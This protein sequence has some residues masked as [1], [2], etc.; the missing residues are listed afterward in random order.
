[1]HKNHL[2]KSVFGLVGLLSVLA[3]VVTSCGDEIP[4]LGVWEVD[5]L[6]AEISVGD[7]F[8]LPLAFNF[9]EIAE[10]NILMQF[11]ENA[12]MMYFERDGEILRCASLDR[13]Y[14]II[15]N[16][17]RVYEENG[18][19]TEWEFSLANGQLTIQM[20]STL[21]DYDGVPILE[22][23]PIVATMTWVLNLVVDPSIVQGVDPDDCVDSPLDRY[24]STYSNFLLWKLVDDAE[25]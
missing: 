15:S 3:L 8:T 5:S 13:A 22:E 24:T 9:M 2:R 25:D 21:A 11:T 18:G 14:E 19:V 10:I 17:V 4:L 12:K 6:D 23:I 1:M 20:T 7:I 16:K